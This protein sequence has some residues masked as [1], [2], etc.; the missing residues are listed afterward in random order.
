MPRLTN[1]S[2]LKRL[3][4]TDYL[5]VSART[6][7]PTVNERLARSGL[8]IA[9]TGPGEAPPVPDWNQL[10]EW[11]IAALEQSAGEVRQTDRDLRKSRV[12]LAQARGDRDRKIDLIA[13]A[14]RALRQSFT[15]TYGVES[16]PLVGLD[17]VPAQA[18]QAVREQMSEVVGR[19]RDP[20]LAESL[21]APQAGQKPIDLESVADAREVEIGDLEAKM[22]EIGR[23][24]KQIDEALVARNQAV[25]ANRRVYSNVGRLFE[26][27]YRL[28][29]LDEL[30]SRIRATERSSRKQAEPDASGA[31]QEG[32]VSQADIS[33]GDELSA[34]WP[35]QPDSPAP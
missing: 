30:A 20:Q 34:G 28:A 1:K 14:H 9:G 19:M 8:E 23:L 27:M 15:G 32:V 6:Q 7:K 17:A 13:A 3:E 25:A 18:L 26:G 29:R 2:V 35:F 22:S 16:L 24:R 10:Q 11:G 12:R 4:K 31:A 33:D 5:I 21:P